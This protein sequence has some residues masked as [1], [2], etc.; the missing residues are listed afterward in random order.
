MD[1]HRR[2]VSTNLL[3]LPIA[4]P[5]S[6]FDW[7]E[8]ELT[9]TE[10]IRRCFSLARSVNVQSVVVEDI[11]ADGLIREENEELLSLVA[12]H[13]MTGLK[14]LSFWTTPLIHTTD[15]LKVDASTLYG[16]A[17][18]K[19]DTVP[20]RA[21]NRWHVFEAV[22]RKYPH[23]H[24]CIPNQKQY[25]IR[26]GEREFAV[27]GVLYAQQN[28]LNK[29]CAHVAL[30][31]LLSRRLSAGDVSYRKLNDLAKST[32]PGVYDP[33]NGLGVQQIRAILRHFKVPFRDID[34]VEEEKKDK[35]IRSSHPFQKF[36]YAGIE[37]GCG[38]LLGFR[39]TG[40]KASTEKH[41][42]P[43]FGHTFNKD[44]WVPDAD[45]AYFNMGGGVGYIPSESW[46]SSFLGH[47]DNFGPNLCIPRLYVTPTQAEYVVELLQEG[48]AYGGVHAEAITLLFLYSLLPYM[49]PNTN[50][51]IRRLMAAAD[52]DSQRVVLRAVCIPRGQYLQHLRDARDWDGNQE[53]PD[54]V[55]ILETGLPETLW[56]VEISLPHLFPANERK[57]GE[58]LLNPF[59]PFDPQAPVDYGLF[60]LARLPG[61]LFVLKSGSGGTPSFLEVASG[62]VS[63]MSLLKV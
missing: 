41:I 60:L 53:N 15:L 61:R 28:T 13:K 63:H 62:I 12:D 54:L 16:Y 4:A 17:I 47:D 33:A 8:Q 2:I 27:T 22:F 36:L 6:C 3:P 5:F 48:V 19:R 46:T 44:T 57:V 51:W 32:G 14:R 38:G 59:V 24:N 1:R 42:I 29:V 9:A 37:S 23:E 45:R 21:M 56:V 58:I 18:V 30:R 52:P 40:P 39:M 34:Y 55:K 25:T 10:S 26:V 20:S 31:T 50:L 49:D 11:P 35:K 7:V 43:F